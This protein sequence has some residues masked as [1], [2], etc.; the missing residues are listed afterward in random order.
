MR[1]PSLRGGL[2]SPNIDGNTRL[3]RSACSPQRPITTVASSWSPL[4]YPPDR[5]DPHNPD[6]MRELAK[7]WNID[8]AGFHPEVPNDIV[9]RQASA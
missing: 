7:L 4:D 1:W 2:Q 5:V 3:C 9:T 6:H 8:P